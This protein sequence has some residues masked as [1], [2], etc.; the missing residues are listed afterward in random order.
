MKIVGINHLGLA[1]KDPVKARWFLS[2][3]LQLPFLGEELVK[4]QKTNTIMFESS[5]SPAISS[6]RL[7]IVA[8]QD[9]EDGPIKK[10]VETKGG[11]IHHMAL[12]V[13]DLDQALVELKAKGVELIDEKPRYGAHNSRIAFIHPRATGGI[14]IELVQVTAEHG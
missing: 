8:N 6:A 3:I 13:D 1:A 12:S 14:L 11:G 4:E 9:G 2:E 5:V 7:E 10:F